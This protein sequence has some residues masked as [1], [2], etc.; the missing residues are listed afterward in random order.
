M[1]WRIVREFFENPMCAV[2]FGYI[3]GY[4]YFKELILLFNHQ[5]KSYVETVSWKSNQNSI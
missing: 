2:F 1:F 5:T 4:M 3:C